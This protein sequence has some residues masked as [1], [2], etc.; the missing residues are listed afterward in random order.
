MEI[1]KPHLHKT[2]QPTCTRVVVRRSACKFLRTKQLS[3]NRAAM[4]TVIQLLLDK[5]GFRNNQLPVLV[6]RQND[7]K[8]ISL[9]HANSISQNTAP[10][11][12]TAPNET[13]TCIWFKTRY[14]FF[15]QGITNDLAG[16]WDHDL[17][18]A[19]PQCHLAVSE[20]VRGHPDCLSVQLVV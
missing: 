5:P 3:G 16:P 10:I 4:S 19:L 12:K 11:G 1:S 8:S 14:F 13:T 2:R 20:R 18:Q 17:L 15:E 6:V 9:S 7:V